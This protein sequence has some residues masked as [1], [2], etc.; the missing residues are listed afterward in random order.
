VIDYTRKMSNSR[1]KNS[2]IN[3]AVATVS[4][5]VFIIMNFICRTVFI[6]ML[7][8][9][10]VGINGLF[11]NILKVL[12]FADLGIGSAITY[13]LYKPIAEGDNE[14]VK[15]LMHFYQKVYS[16]IATFIFAIGILIIP[17]LGK[18]VEV[19]QNVTENIT[20][21]YILFLIKTVVL[22]FL[23]YKK[24][25][26]RGHQKEYIVSL[27][28]LFITVIQNVLEII[29]LIVTRN[30]IVYL[31]IQMGTSILQNIIISAIANKMYPYI[32]EKEYT[33]ITKE[34][35]KSIFEDVKSFIFYKF[36][37]VISDGTDSIIISSFLG[38][39]QVGFLANYLTITSAVT[40]LVKAVFE[41]LTASIGNLNTI[42]ERLK[43]ES[44]FYE[45]LLLSFLIYGYVSIATTLLM[46]KF[47]IIWL[48]NDYLLAIS[49]SVALGFNMYI[50]GM[51]YANNTFRNTLGL[52]KK[53]RFV[54]LISS[55]VNI[56]LSIILVQYIGMFGVLIATGITRL[57]IV[58]WYDP[59][60]IHS[61]EFK[62]SC[63][64]YYITYFY[65]LLIEILTFG[66]CYGIITKISLT[67]IFGFVVSG[68]V[69]TVIIFAIFMMATFR[70]KEFEDLK[71]RKKNILWKIKRT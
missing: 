43:K 24:S 2:A 26:I 22:Y 56:V 50:D 44:V 11:T 58:T 63:K 23:I 59:Y 67:G 16:V 31:I 8:T 12:S 5:I 48:G 38:V 15:T 20:V 30:F 69:I 36:G 64:R 10:Y 32:K 71:N 60:L 29:F 66:I 6:Q 51:M 49:I 68:L 37:Y 7:G 3:V 53:G 61:N 45:I 17:F 47:I 55:I 41:A 39:I 33:Q 35:K 13:K 21:I 4:K 52:F 70:L 14:R 46:N 65:Y 34:E 27:I 25:I 1:T 42:K 40:T 9:E 62:T 54:P 28:E 57:L 19:S 18:I